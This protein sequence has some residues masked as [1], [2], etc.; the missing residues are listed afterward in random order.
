MTAANNPTRVVAIGEPSPTQDQIVNA[1]GTSA[2]AD[3]QLVDV[4]VPSENLVRDIRS[5][6][7]KLIIVDYQT[8]EQSILD[9]IDDLSL[10]IPEIAIVAIIPGNDPLVAQ[11]VT[12]AGARAFLVHPFTQVNLL[13]TLRRVR[14]IEMRHVRLQPAA[15]AIPDDQINP[16]KTIAVYSPRGGAGC[17]TVAVNLAIALREKTDQRVLLLGGKLFFGHLG[18]MLNLRTNNSIADLIPHAA[19]LDDALIQDVVAGHI[20][21]IDVLLEPFDFQVA[22]GIRPQELYNILVGLKKVYNYIVIDTGS[23]LTENAVTLMDTADRI[24]LVTTP[25]LASLH[26]A[27][28]F[29]EISRSLDYQSGKILVTL[30]RAGLSGGIKSKDVATS[31]NQELF[32]EI[33]DD[34]ARVLRS[35]N[36]GI[37]LLLRYPRSPASKAIHGLV[38]KLEQKQDL[39]FGSSRVPSALPAA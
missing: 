13:S 32:A 14:E 24:L 38:H 3:F 12:L 2:Q 21:G 5:A 20:S 37:P 25:E 1:L 16:L 8:G 29:V 28:R 34:D 10:Q 33:P 4:I 27:K 18:L 9:I 19:Q 7:P 15:Q 36:R 39:V 11:Q 6:E 17:S 30:N 31:L 26:D 22:Q 35:L 23:E